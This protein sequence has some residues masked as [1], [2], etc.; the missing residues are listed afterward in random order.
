MT[1]RLGVRTGPLASTVFEL[2]LVQATLVGRV[3]NG[4]T[5]DV[6]H[7]LQHVLYLDLTV[8]LFLRR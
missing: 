1:M 5:F 7:R 6:G 4:I 3:A 8:V 2:V